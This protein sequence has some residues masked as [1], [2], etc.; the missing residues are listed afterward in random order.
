MKTD[1]HQSH[2]VLPRNNWQ[3]QQRGFYA[4]FFIPFSVQRILP[5]DAPCLRPGDDPVADDYSWNRLSLYCRSRDDILSLKVS[6][7]LMHF[8][9]V[10]AKFIFTGKKTF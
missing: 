2:S 10:Q 3:Y 7:I 1:S 8:V 9:I 5:L 6:W 4:S